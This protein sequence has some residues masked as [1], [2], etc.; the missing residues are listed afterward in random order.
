MSA[1]RPA[2]VAFLLLSLHCEAANRCRLADGRILYT[3]AG[4]DSVGG[5][6]DRAM[7]NEISV[8]PLPSEGKPE[9]RKPVPARATAAASGAPFR[10]APNSPVLTV[11][12][13]AANARTGIGVGEV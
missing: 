13:D 12:Y 2:A 5:K 11:C 3:D 1:L 6:L 10:K 7:K 8:V 4:C 9:A